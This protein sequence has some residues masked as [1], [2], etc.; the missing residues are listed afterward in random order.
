MGEG[1]RGLH[2]LEISLLRGMYFKEVKAL[3]SRLSNS[4]LSDKTES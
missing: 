3:G 1:T 4:L 2:V